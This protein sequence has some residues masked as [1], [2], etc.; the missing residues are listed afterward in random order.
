M[1]AVAVALLP[2]AACLTVCFLTE[3]SDS[4]SVN[5]VLKTIGPAEPA[6]QEKPGTP[7][8]GLPYLDLLQS[9]TVL[10]RTLAVLTNPESPAA[11]EWRKSRQSWE[12]AQSS[13]SWASL[14]RALRQL[15]AE[16]ERLRGDQTKTQ[17]AM[18][19]LGRLSERVS[20][21]DRGNRIRSD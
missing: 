7:A 18:L 13:E 10:A 1:Q 6:G 8:P 5:L 3:W 2:V 11:S 12:T 21:S 20:V 4:A 9:E 15:D 16:I 17:A 14:S 19:N